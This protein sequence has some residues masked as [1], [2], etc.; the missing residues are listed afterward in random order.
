M[1]HSPN[2]IC[3]SSMTI[4]YNLLGQFEPVQFIRQYSKLMK[5]ND[6]ESSRLPNSTAIDC[7]YTRSFFIEIVLIN[8]YHIYRFTATMPTLRYHHSTKH[9]MKWRKTSCASMVYSSHWKIV[10]WAPAFTATY[11]KVRGLKFKCFKMII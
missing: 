11:I 4:N 3:V 10:F 6:D 7:K 2:R 8:I 5:L 1:K 9:W